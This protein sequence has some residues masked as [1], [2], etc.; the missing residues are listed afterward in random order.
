MGWIPDSDDPPNNKENSPKVRKPSISISY[1]K[2]QQ[3]VKDLTDNSSST[4][5][6]INTNNSD[7]N[8][9]IT[10]SPSTSQKTITNTNL[11]MTDCPDGWGCPNRYA[12]NDDLINNDDS[13]PSPST[14]KSTSTP[15]SK[16]QRN[17]L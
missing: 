3:F 4:I 14:I 2:I 17:V 12:S 9:I 1:T 10:P 6:T 15:S 13:T 16:S 7:N 8:D 5:H 11:V